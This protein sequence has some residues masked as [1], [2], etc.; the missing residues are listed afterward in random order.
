[1]ARGIEEKT[2][3]GLLVKAFVAEV[4]EELDDEA[5][6]EALEARLDDWFADARV[7]GE[8]WLAAPREPGG[9]SPTRGDRRHSPSPL[10]GEGRLA[11]APEG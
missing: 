1:M 9:S 4:I 8:R 11:R 7:K 10:A 6:V 3:R 2:A 5:I